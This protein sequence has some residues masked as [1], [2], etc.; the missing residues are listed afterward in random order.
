MVSDLQRLD[1]YESTL[2]FDFEIVVPQIRTIKDR[3]RELLM[4]LLYISMSLLFMSLM[5]V[6]ALAVVVAILGIAHS[7]DVVILSGAYLEGRWHIS[8]DKNRAGH[9]EC[10]YCFRGRLPLAR[11]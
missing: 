11:Q 10:N 1:E 2:P 8:S 5:S 7:N 6:R 4:S 9:L 3:S